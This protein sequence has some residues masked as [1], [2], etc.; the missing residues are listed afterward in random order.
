[1]CEEELGLYS[2]NG[3]LRLNQQG[4]GSPLPWPFYVEAIAYQLLCLFG[5][6]GNLLVLHIIRR[7][8]KAEYSTSTCLYRL[9]ALVL[10]VTLPL[11]CVRNVF[12]NSGTVYPLSLNP[13]ITYIVANILGDLLYPLENL[14]LSLFL[15][16][17]ADRYVAVFKPFHRSVLF[18]CSSNL[19]FFVIALAFVLFL[20]I[21]PQLF[22]VF[23]QLLSYSEINT[24]DKMLLVYQNDT[25]D[26]QS[27]ISDTFETKQPENNNLFISSINSNSSVDPIFS[28]TLHASAID[29][30]KYSGIKLSIDDPVVDSTSNPDTELT[31]STPGNSLLSIL[32]QLWAI[33]ELLVTLLPIV[34]VGIS[35]L[36]YA[37]HNP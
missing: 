3:E 36:M 29:H 8:S 19:H 18:R 37:L 26:F 23:K 17:V 6:A 2:S 16:L 33:I 24:R 31:Y 35:V 4:S 25:S 27:E 5:F 14:L 13:C 12:V 9:V 11:L 28:S 10:S 22:S 20:I 7:P 32:L 15:L 30:Q 1:M 21:T 34:I